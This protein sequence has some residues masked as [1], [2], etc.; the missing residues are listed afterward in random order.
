MS[1]SII[2]NE[3]YRPSNLCPDIAYAIN[4]CERFTP[5]PKVSHATRVK[6]VL[7]Y[8]KGTKTK[9]MT[10]QPTVTHDVH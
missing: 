3:L 10:I 5:N 1:A 4:Q 2:K 9:V 6:R 8:L 7:R